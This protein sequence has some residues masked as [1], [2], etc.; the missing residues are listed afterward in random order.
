MTRDADVLTRK[1]AR[2]DI[3][4][5]ERFLDPRPDARDVAEVRGFGEVSSEDC[6][7][8][9]IYLDTPHVANP[10]TSEP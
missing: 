9:T 1:A 3:D 6:I 5:S 8:R 2:D 4:F 7:T 10:G